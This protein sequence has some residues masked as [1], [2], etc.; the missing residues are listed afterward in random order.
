MYKN[1]VTP[2]VGDVVNVDVPAAKRAHG[3]QIVAV[4]VACGMG[5]CRVTP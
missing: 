3:S 5:S 1:N 4:Y 2:Q